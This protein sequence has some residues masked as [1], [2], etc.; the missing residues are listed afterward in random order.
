VTEEHIASGLSRP[1]AGGVRGETGEEH[2]AGLEVD[3]EQ[4]VVAAQG[5]GVDGE[6]V[7]GDGCL[8]AEELGPGH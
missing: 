1:A 7:A 8:G 4:H 2:L 3:E 5:H 6:E